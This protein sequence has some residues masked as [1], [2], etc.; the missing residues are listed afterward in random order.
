MCGGLKSP[1]TY[2]PGDLTLYQQT[3]PK[4]LYEAEEKIIYKF[5]SSK[6]CFF[7]DNRQ[8]YILNSANMFVLN[9]DFPIK[10]AQLSA[11]LNSRF[12][13]WLFFK[14]FKTHK[15]LRA[16]LESLP[17][18]AGYFEHYNKFSEEKYLDYLNIIKTDHEMYVFKNG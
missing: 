18:H 4:T 9:K 8:R 16:D 7:C 12:M 15:I 11:L 13:N 10:S 2:I 3:A 1:S 5:I 14:I 17:I 6:L